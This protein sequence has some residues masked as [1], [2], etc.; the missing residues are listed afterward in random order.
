MLEQNIHWVDAFDFY[1]SIDF[2]YFYRILR[3]HNITITG[4]LGESGCQCKYRLGICKSEK[5]K[6]LKKIHNVALGKL[7]T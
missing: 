6:I 3:N 1:I 4:F 2:S 7:L 5:L